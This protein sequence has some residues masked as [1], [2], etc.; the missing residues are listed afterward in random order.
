MKKKFTVTDI[1][2]V[3]ALFLLPVTGCGKQEVPPL[4]VTPPPTAVPDSS[5]VI[6][7]EPEVTYFPQGIT[8]ITYYTLSEELEVEEVTSPITGNGEMTAQE[9]VA[10][11]TATMEDVSV[12]VT[13]DSVTADGANAV[14][15]FE[16]DSV[17][18]RFANTRLESA[19]LDA[20]A[21]SL[22]DNFSEYAGVIFRAGGQAYESENRSFELN[23]IYMG[24]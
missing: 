18:V 13:V 24:R 17:P 3:V 2:L 7:R 21:Q 1:L 5:G 20:L 16:S 14:V 12:T 6:G 23:E 15:D 22:L 10:Y 19:I 11:V 9:L 4:E 8:N